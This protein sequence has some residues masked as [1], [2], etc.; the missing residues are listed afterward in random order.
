MGP[1]QLLFLISSLAVIVLVILIILKNNR[2]NKDKDNLRDYLLYLFKNKQHEEDDNLVVESFKKDTNDPVFK[3]YFKTL[4]EIFSSIKSEKTLDLKD[5][6]RILDKIPYGILIVD[7]QR[8]VLSLN[9]SLT[10]LFYLDKNDVLGKK[11]ILV[12]NNQS[13]E[14]LI[15]QVLLEG[16]PLKEDIIFFGDEE[17]H[18]D[19][20]ISPVKILENDDTGK[21]ARRSDLLIIIRNTTQEAEFSKLRSQ[22]VANISH[23]MKTPLT[24]I[25]GYVET[26]IDSDFRKKQTIKGYLEK[27]LNNVERLNILIDD[28]LNLSKIEFKRNILYE[29]KHDLKDIIQEIIESLKIIAQKNEIDISF[30]SPTEPVYFLTDEDL[31]RQLVKNMLENSIFHSGKG[32]RVE[33]S[34]STTE[35]NTLLIFIDNGVGIQKN[36]QPYIFQRFFRGKNPIT[37]KKIG[38]GLGLSIVKHIVE[39]HNGSITLKS[40]PNEETRFTIVLP[41]KSGDL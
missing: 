5:L 16:K 36:D 35:K 21:D 30:N 20:E 32:S 22:F 3:E 15:S 33:I 25:K 28:V 9:E 2:V 4:D 29:K 17:I 31:F 38:S 37:S 8:K 41:N 11:T 27:V 10:S 7:S 24:S 26:A 39:L 14:E 13:L 12:F 34:L 40:I 6:D 1:F 19:V 18:L 23:E